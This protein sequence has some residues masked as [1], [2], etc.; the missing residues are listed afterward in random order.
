[1]NEIDYE[2]ISEDDFDFEITT[3]DDCIKEKI[4][5]ASFIPEIQGVR[6][7]M[8]WTEIIAM[9]N[10]KNKTGKKINTQIPV[11]LCIKLYLKLVGKSFLS[12]R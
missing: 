11:G 4:N 3:V 9:I 8:R 2:N 10:R 6:F 1:M 5:P 12:I 7:N